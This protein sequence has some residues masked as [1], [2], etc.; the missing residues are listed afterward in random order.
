MG[1]EEA[2]KKQIKGLTQIDSFVVWKFVSAFEFPLLDSLCN[3]SSFFVPFKLPSI[4]ILFQSRL[5]RVFIP[6]ASTL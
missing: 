6:K 2:R 3:N 4:P 5:L 1:K